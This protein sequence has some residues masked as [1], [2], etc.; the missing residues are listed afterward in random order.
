MSYE[1]GHAIGVVIGFLLAP[2]LASLPTIVA[3]TNNHP[4]KNII[5]AVNIIGALFWGIF[6]VIGLTSWI[7]AAVMC[8]PPEEQKGTTNT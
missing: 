8:A 2:L 1:T 7:V 4:K 6:W 3:F 5:A